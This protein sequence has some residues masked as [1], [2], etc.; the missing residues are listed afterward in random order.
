MGLQ[1]QLTALRQ[2]EK[3]S[4]GGGM[5]GNGQR[6]WP[7]FPKGNIR[8]TEACSCCREGTGTHEFLVRKTL[9]SFGIQQEVH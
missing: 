4:R 2:G 3:L 9:S 8:E 6:R 1:L 7:T 5:D